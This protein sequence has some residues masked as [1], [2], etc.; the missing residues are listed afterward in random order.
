MRFAAGSGAVGLE[1]TAGE[2]QRGCRESG[3]TCAFVGH[4]SPFAAEYRSAAGVE[5]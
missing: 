4:G 3:E 2:Q 1:R 5:S